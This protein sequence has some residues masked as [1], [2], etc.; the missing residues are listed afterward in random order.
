MIVSLV[1][2]IG[3]RYLNACHGDIACEYE[4]EGKPQQENI[5]LEEY[6]QW[7]FK[8]FIARLQS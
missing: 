8:L 7:R 5:H 4:H 2:R 1:G 6:R 3:I